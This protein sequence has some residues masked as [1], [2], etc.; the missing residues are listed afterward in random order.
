M[1]F[2][3]STAIFFCSI[4]EWDRV[5]ALPRHKF[6]TGATLLQLILDVPDESYSR[7]AS[8]V[9][10]LISTC[11]LPRQNNIMVNMLLPNCWRRRSTLITV[12]TIIHISLSHIWCSQFILFSLCLFTYFVNINVY[13]DFVKN[14]TVAVLFLYVLLIYIYPFCCT[15]YYD[16][17]CTRPLVV[18]DRLPYENRL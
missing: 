2:Y 12:Q 13:F 9:L 7:D 15:S 4:V 11:L 18:F 6:V 1:S 8:C 5:V 3:V 16:Y 14:I 10:N 17:F